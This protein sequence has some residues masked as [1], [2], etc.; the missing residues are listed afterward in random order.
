MKKT[1]MM[2][3]AALLLG[4]G[5]PL[6]TI[7]PPPHSTELSVEANEYNDGRTEYGTLLAATIP[8][9]SEW[10]VWEDLTD[11]FRVAFAKITDPNWK[12]GEKYKAPYLIITA[13]LKH[14][15]S[16][17][18]VEVLKGKRETITRDHPEGTVSIDGKDWHYA[19]PD[20]EPNLLFGMLGDTVVQIKYN[21]VDIFNDQ[22]VHRLISSIGVKE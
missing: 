15:A 22:D 8:D 10:H 6:G 18:L 11:D 13:D 7:T 21:N 14:R 20:T 4:C 12:S 16:P 1:T 2:A 5:A 19:I 17:K 9:Q 3:V